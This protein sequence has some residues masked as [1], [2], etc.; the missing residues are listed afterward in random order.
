MKRCICTIISL[1]AIVS[2][3]VAI[4]FAAYA[5]P[6]T[7]KFNS[8]KAATDPLYT[9]W[10][11]Y[12]KECVARSG[13]TLNI[14]M[15]ASEALGSA[16]DVLSM[17]GQ[18]APMLVDCDTSFI[19]EYVPDW[20]LFMYPYLIQKPSDFY[21]LLE[22]DFGKELQKRTEEKGLKLMA[23]AFFGTRNL[24][25]S[26]PVKSREDTAKMKIRVVNTKMYNEIAGVLGGNPTNVPWS[27]TYMALQQGV[28]D[29][30]EPGTA[31]METAKLYEPCK[32]IALTEHV[33]TFTT[34]V[35]SSEVFNSLPE[36][37]QKAIEEM[38][39]TYVKN[40]MLKFTLDLEEKAKGRLTAQGVTL[41]AVDK[42]PFIKASELII[43]KFPE[44]TPGAYDR[45]KTILAE[46][47]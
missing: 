19:A 46:N 33:I 45:V 24:I 22:S 5:Q 11:D 15:Y 9:T 23:A 26:K 38:Q 40:E 30:A 27:E 6:V 37:A 13:G 34:V 18:G 21:Y 25:S 41:T 16:S 39:A 47:K 14:E 31:L 42:A 28:A 17:I 3:G 44:F 10:E 7:L 4:P 36:Q 12:A 2:L 35:M 29:A 20:N 1:F 43:S 8:V 32:Y